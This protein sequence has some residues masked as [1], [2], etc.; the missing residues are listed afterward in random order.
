MK[1]RSIPSLCGALLL[2]LALSSCAKRGVDAEPVAS[3]E[4]AGG[5]DAVGELDILEAEL[6]ARIE[7]LRELR[8][9]FTGPA[10]QEVAGIGGGDGDEATKA[11]EVPQPATERVPPADR[12]SGG[13]CTEVCELSASICQLQ[14]Q[15]CGLVRRHEGEPRYVQACER[16]KGDCEF[17]TEACHACG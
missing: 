4:A 3:P 5:A 16:A 14:D 15:I 9:G 13:K 11:S 1:T 12:P 6:A 10:G 8:P 2:G 17:A 7:R